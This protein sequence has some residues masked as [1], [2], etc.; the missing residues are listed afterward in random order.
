MVPV[1]DSTLVEDHLLNAG[2]LV[3]LEQAIGLYLHMLEVF[4]RSH[5]DLRAQD[6]LT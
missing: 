2:V 3:Y 6:C 4:D 5:S 1:H